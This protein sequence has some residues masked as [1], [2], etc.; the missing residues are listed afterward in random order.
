MHLWEVEHAYYCNLGNYYNNGCGS[1]YESFEEFL[2]E[3]G[4]SDL[5]YNLL[6]RWDWKDSNN[7]DNEIEQD[8]LQIFWMLQRKG[9]YLFSVIKVNKE[10]E[11]KVIEFLKPR[12]EY[13]KALWN[14]LDNI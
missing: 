4:N 7:K 12:W 10:D 11:K 6:F 2:E 8:E 3:W 13:M 5:D 9:N 1:Y 14:P